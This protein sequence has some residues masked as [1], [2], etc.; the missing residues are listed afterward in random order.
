[1]YEERRIDY[2]Y[3]HQGNYLLVPNTPVEVC[4]NCGMIYFDAPILKEIERRFF[5]IQQ[6]SEQ[7]DDY[8]QMPIAAYA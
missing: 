4:L 8:I 3:S 2:L 7:P 5:A 1:R 6:N